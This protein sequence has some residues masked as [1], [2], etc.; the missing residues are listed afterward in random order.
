MPVLSDELL[1]KSIILSENHTSKKIKNEEFDGW[2]YLLQI[3]KVKEPFMRCMPD[4]KRIKIIDNNFFWL[5]SFPRGRHYSIITIFNENL[6][7]IQWIFDLLICDE[8]LGDNIPAMKKCY[9]NITI[10]G[11]GRFYIINEELL[12]KAF[13][14]NQITSNEYKLISQTIFEIICNY[15]NITKLKD[16][17][18]K[19]LKMFNL[20]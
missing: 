17:S 13:S 16:F 9:I 3:N 20:F 11:D 1:I 15:N 6:Q 5:K 19:Y 18:M 12:S 2:L 8:S 10:N 14:N 7:V 4:E